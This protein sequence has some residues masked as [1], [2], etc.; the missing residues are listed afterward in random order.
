MKIKLS[1]ITAIAVFVLSIACSKA[2]IIDVLPV[3]GAYTYQA[4]D[5]FHWTTGT[6]ATGNFYMPV[7]GAETY[8]DA[9]ALAAA[10]GRPT[11]VPANYSAHLLTV[12]SSEEAAMIDAIFPQGLGSTWIAVDFTHESNAANATYT[13]GPENG[14]LVSSFSY[15][16][17]WRS[18]DPSAGQIRAYL[19]CNTGEWAGVL[20]GDLG[21]FTEG[22]VVEF[23]IIPE[24]SSFAVMFGV[25][26]LLFAV[27]RRRKA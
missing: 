13:A 21:T 4:G 24:P 6:G 14:L 20:A 7:V 25:A 11:G 1:H 16:P 23:S 2:A 9:Y 17:D 15:S 5:V 19:D 8:D 3:P 27:A 26:S 22:Y 12:T 10:T 18:G